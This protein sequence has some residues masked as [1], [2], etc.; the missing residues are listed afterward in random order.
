MSTFAEQNPVEQEHA[1]E[2]LARGR[3]LAVHDSMCSLQPTGTDYRIDLVIEKDANAPMPEV[4]KRA[5][6]RITAQALRLHPATAGGCFIEPLDGPPRIVAGRIRRVDRQSRRL[7][8]EA[9]L[10]FWIQLHSSDDPGQWEA[11]Q[12]I[13]C[14]VE[15]G[16]SFA[17]D[18]SK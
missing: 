6:G 2:D 18:T 17:I 3:V 14:Y 10:P 11:G 7:L 9:V 16:T 8:V 12:M 15:S 4:G 13:N 5:K 1:G